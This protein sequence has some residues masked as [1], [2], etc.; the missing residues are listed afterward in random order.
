MENEPTQDDTDGLRDDDCTIPPK[1]LPME[2]P[3]EVAAV[4]AMAK[5]FYQRY[6]ACTAFYMG[7]LIE[8][9]QAAFMSTATEEVRPYIFL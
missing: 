7:S 6:D 5:C 1:A 2:Y 9:C 3:N 4:E 8:A